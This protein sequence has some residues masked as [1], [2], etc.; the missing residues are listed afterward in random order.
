MK[1]GA[2]QAE[3]RQPVPL[4]ECIGDMM[5]HSFTRIGITGYENHTM[6][7]VST[8]MDSMGTGIF[9]MQG[10]A[11]VD[12]KIITQTGSHNDPIEGLMELRAVTRIVDDN[13][14]IF[15]MYGTGKR[16]TDTKMMEITCQRK[17]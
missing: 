2:L 12:G 9:F 5:G 17:E 3:P 10:T 8:W 13:T 16:G 4:Q 7:Y 15:E 14:E 11:S 1:Q 6:T